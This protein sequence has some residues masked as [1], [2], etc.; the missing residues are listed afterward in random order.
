M[1]P[2]KYVVPYKLP[3]YPTTSAEFGVA[4]L[5][6]LKYAIVEKVL[7]GINL[8]AVPMPLANCEF[9]MPP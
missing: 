8:N 7:S 5:V 4:P 3:S 9:V 2:P 1:L 6:P